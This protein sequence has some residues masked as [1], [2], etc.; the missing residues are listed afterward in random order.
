[1]DTDSDVAAPSPAAVYEDFL[2]RWQFRQWAAAL[3]AQAALRPRERVLDLAP[4]TAHRPLGALTA[5]GVS[6]SLSSSQ[7]STR[8]QPATCARTRE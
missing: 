5:A 6:R 4:S 8:A 2:V 7:R 3:L 1:M